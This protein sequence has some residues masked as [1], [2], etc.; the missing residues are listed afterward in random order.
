MGSDGLFF[1][2]TA[3]DCSGGGGGDAV[4]WVGF[5]ALFE[6]LVASTLFSLRSGVGRVHLATFFFLVTLTST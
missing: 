5:A 4:V 3:E 6:A 2:T 1:F